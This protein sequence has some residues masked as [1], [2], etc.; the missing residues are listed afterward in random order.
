MIFLFVALYDR[1]VAQKF[2]LKIFSMA[3][4][5]LKVYPKYRPLT[6]S[7]SVRIVPELR[8]C[9]QWLERSGFKIG[10]QVQIT[11]RDRE[12]II[13]PVMN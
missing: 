5:K 12:I 8:L 4:R 10:E 2:F 7:Y 1:Y 13:K 9:G 6:N 3:D 11:I